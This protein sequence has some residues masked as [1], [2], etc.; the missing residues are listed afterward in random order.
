MF[1]TEWSGEGFLGTELDCYASVLPVIASDWNA[2]AEIIRHGEAGLIYLRENFE[3]L[4][5][6]IEWAIDHQQD[7]EKMKKNC[8]EEYEHYTPE[9]IMALVRER[10]FS[11]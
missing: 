9:R 2:N 3:N 5:G 10:L 6:S 4:T 11:N 8:R 1:P 7:F